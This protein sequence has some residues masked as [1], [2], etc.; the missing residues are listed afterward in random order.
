MEL[1]VE[2][3]HSRLQERRRL[4]RP[5]TRERHGVIDS[6]LVE[7]RQRSRGDEPGERRERSGGS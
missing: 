2:K 3:G 1:R 6:P 7:V 5:T 4:R